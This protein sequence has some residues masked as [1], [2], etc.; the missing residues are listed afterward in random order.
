MIKYFLQTPNERLSLLI[1]FYV[2]YL[3]LGA[4][5]FDAVESPH[6]AKIIR[7]LNEYV[8]QFRL[9]HNACLTDDELNSF[10][11]LVIYS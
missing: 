1:V 4:L 3:F 10:I 8:K 7:N 5:V 6:E 11:R 2:F 9:K